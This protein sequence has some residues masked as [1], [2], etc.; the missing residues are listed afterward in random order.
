MP[1]KDRVLTVTETHLFS[2][3]LVNEFRFGYIR[4]N[5]SAVNVPPV[6]VDDVGIDRPTN[7]LTNN[8]YKFTFASSGFQFGPTPQADTANTQN[9]LEFVETLSWVR[10]KHTLRVG[11]EYT[12]VSLDKL[13]PQVFNGQLFFVNTGDG[14]TDFQ[15]FLL[16]SPA[17][18][19]GGGGVYNHEYRQNNYALFAQDDWKIRPDLTLN[20]GLRTE[21]LGAFQDD[22]CH[23]GNLESDLTNSGSYPFVYPKCASGLNVTGLTGT[24]SGSTFRNNTA[25]GWGPRIGF[26]WDVFGHHTTTVRGGYGIYYVREDVGTIDQLSFQAP[27][28]PIAFGGGAPGSLGAFFSG[29]LATNPNA[30]PP[31]GTI[32]PTYIPCLSIFTGFPDGTNGAASYDQCS[33]GGTVP[34]VGIF[35]LEVPRHFIVPN[36]QQWNLTVQQDLGKSWVVE[37]GYVGAK[38]THLRETRDGIQ[39]L[40]ASDSNPVVLTDPNGQS[41]NITT[42]TFANAIARTPTVGLNGYSGYQLF[43]ND[44][45]SIYHSFQATLTRRWGRGYFQGAY[46]FSKSIDATSTGNTAFNTA[47][48]DQSSINA[49]RGLSDFDRPHRLTVSYG[50]ELPF[51]AHVQARFTGSGRVGSQWGH[52]LQSGAPFSIFDSGAGTAFLGAG[53]TPLL[54]ASLDPALD[55]E[56]TFQR[57]HPSADQRIFEPAASPRPHRCSLPLIAPDDPNFCATDFGDLRRNIYRGPFQQNWDFSLIKH[58]RSSSARTFASPPI[59]STCGTMRISPTRSHRY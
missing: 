27:I 24:A 30:L 55:L 13:F 32:D 51:Y 6:T 29:S 10:G 41:F 46:T 59:S 37:L 48:N 1:V 42:N 9:N 36:T 2:P 18:S 25:T 57:R 21:F 38:G 16:G 7:N 58:F 52:H 53:S 22:A 19:F 26:A 56:R 35:G 40:R 3:A 45:Y 5:N 11:G 43:A 31:A 47:Y 14:L 49:S 20:L 15:N 23:I 12:H 28:L 4:I 50:Y 8:I 54:G 44:A 39:S 17:F 34:S 33:G